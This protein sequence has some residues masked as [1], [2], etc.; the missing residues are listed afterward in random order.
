MALYFLILKNALWN[1]ICMLFAFEMKIHMWKNGRF[2]L[3]YTEKK[4]AKNVLHPRKCKKCQ[5]AEVDD[6][7]IDGKI[8]L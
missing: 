7:G 1:Q 5:N 6:S 4:G 8:L 3:L 2:Y